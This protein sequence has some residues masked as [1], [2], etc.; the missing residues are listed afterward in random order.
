MRKLSIIILGVALLMIL[1]TPLAAK[2]CGGG[3]YYPPLASRMHVGMK[4][5]TTYTASGD[6]LRVRETPGLDG[7]Y[8][9]QFYNGTKFNIV[10]GPVEMSGYTWWQIT[11]PDGK[12]NGWLAESGEGEYWIQGAN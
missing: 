3:M 6:P 5:M 11:T 2:A 4:A 7:K 12:V 9:T 1:S 8:L 10:N